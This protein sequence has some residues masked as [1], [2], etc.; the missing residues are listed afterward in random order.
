MRIASFSLRSTTLISLVSL[1]FTLVLNYAFYAKVLKLHPFTGETEDYFLVTVPF[2]VF[3]VLNAVFQ[4][5]A[6]PVL[7]KII[8]PALLMISAAV[9]YSEVFLDVYFT[10][11]MLENVLQTNFAEASRTVT[12]P[13]ILWILGFGVFP[14]LLYV[15]VKVD[16][17]R[18]YK[19]IAY[20]I[21]M[22]LLSVVV[23][24]GIAKGFY[25]DYAS[26][27]RNNKSVPA[28]IVPS[29]FISAG[30]NEVK[31]IQQANMPYTELGLDAAQE[32]PDDYLHLTV[33]VVGETTRAQNWGLNGYQPQ[34][35]PL[36]A[37]RG[38]QIIN[39]KNVTSCGT[40]TAVSVPCMFSGMG[41]D[42]YDAVKAAHQDNILD[43]LQR[44]GVEILWIDNNSDCKGVCLRVPSKNIVSSTDP[45]YCQDGECLDNILL[46]HIDD[47]LRNLKKDTVL[48]LHTIGSHGPTYYE[49]YIPEYRRFTPTCDTNEIQKCTNEQLVNTYN[50]GILY[51]D[52]F[53]D[54]VIE[55]VSAHSELEAA[56]YYLSDHGESLGENG[57]YLHGTPYAIAPAQQTHIPMIM[58][59][60]DRFKENENIDFDCLRKNA[61]QQSYSQDNLYSTLF[62]LMD[63]NPN[64]SVYQE[65]LDIIAQCKQK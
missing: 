37:A 32:K 5:F 61:A 25:Q 14:S 13:Y 8:M 2:F 12:L 18:W 33:L 7:H 48:V 22:I 21:A 30:I 40:S 57:V 36:L 58:W 23:I 55:K 44:A 62:G 29:N 34:T 59:F 47:V 16:Y 63:M 65:K 64:T 41:K 11:D 24:A 60:S 10:T 9:G 52:Q 56:V 43:V 54:N 49:R 42:N 6:L 4:L 3:F 51:I 45:K 38:D 26:F 39:F 17:R 27:V 53:L 31:R 20:R 46:D 15:L 28:L 50:N 35:T 19:E 1:Y